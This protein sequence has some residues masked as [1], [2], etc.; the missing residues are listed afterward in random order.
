MTA[1]S[2]RASP[3]NDPHSVD[4]SDPVANAAPAAQ[5]LCRAGCVV[6][7]TGMQR[8]SAAPP[9]LAGNIGVGL[10]LVNQVDRNESRRLRAESTRASWLP[11][12]PTRPAAVVPQSEV[13]H[14]DTRG[15]A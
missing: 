1:P 3:L 8:E 13:P 9:G 10:R 6:E 11:C 15:C 5:N 7:V 2:E 14:G 4:A 12:G